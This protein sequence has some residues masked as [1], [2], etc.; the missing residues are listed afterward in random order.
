[1]KQIGLALHNYHDKFNS[2]PSGFDVNPDGTY[3]GRGWN[4]KLLP[5]TDAADLYHKMEPHLANGIFG[6]QDAPELNQ[7]LPSLCCPSDTDA[8]KVPHAKMV[9]S[10]VVDGMVVPG[11]QNWESLL[12]RSNYVGNVGYL[13]LESGGIQ[14]NSAAVPTTLGPLVNTGSLG[15]VP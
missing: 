3:Q 10:K 5:Y 14:S 6:L 7:W 4:L 8:E 15:S 2:F 13:Q 9:T 11:T 1:M 12:P